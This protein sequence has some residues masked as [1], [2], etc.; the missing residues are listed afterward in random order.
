MTSDGGGW[1]AGL[2]GGSLP[3]AGNISARVPLIG[4]QPANLTTGESYT[5]PS[6]FRCL[7]AVYATLAGELIH[8]REIMHLRERRL[9]DVQTNLEGKKSSSFV[10][11]KLSWKENYKTRFYGSRTIKYCLGLIQDTEYILYEPCYKNHI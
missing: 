5:I 6:L 1:R 2:S 4:L 3:P 9:S 7:T 10:F 11:E 8:P